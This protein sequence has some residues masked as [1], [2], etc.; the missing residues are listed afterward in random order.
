MK[1]R[2]GFVVVGFLLFGVSIVAQTGSTGSGSGAVAGEFQ[3]RVGKRRQRQAADRHRR[4]D[5]LLVSRAQGGEPLWMET[6]NAQADKTGHYSVALGSTSSR[7][8]PAKRLCYRRK[9]RWLGRPG[10]RTRGT[11]ARPVDER[12][13]CVKGS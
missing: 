7:G 8:L 10:S 11:T 13:L 5:L 3:R 2:I 12:A 1:L 4:R 6:Q 9:A